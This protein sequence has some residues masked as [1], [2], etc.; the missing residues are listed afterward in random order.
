MADSGR[1]TDYQDLINKALA[2]KQP[3]LA[4]HYERLRNKKIAE[5][6]GGNE[7]LTYNYQSAYTA[8][9]EGKPTGAWASGVP[10][11][12]GAY[13][14]ASKYSVSDD[15]YEKEKKEFLRQQTEAKRKAFEEKYASVIKENQA[16]KNAAAGQ[17]AQ[18]AQGFY[19]NAA[20]SGLNS[21]AISQHKDASG[22]VLQNYMDTQDK[23]AQD[24]L[25]ALKKSYD[26]EVAAL[27]KNITSA[28]RM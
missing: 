2:T 24:Q 18:S 23:S 25:A 15:T 4:A 5:G 14:T 17:S 19:E 28:A 7:E 20:A 13:N 9:S 12:M 6:Y 21:G 16:K 22:R 11:E 3:A 1:D 27:K 10:D 8:D 26:E